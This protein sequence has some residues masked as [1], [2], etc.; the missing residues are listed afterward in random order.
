MIPSLQLAWMDEWRMAAHGCLL[1]K[2]WLMCHYCIAVKTDAAI[3]NSFK[4]EQILK[5]STALTCW[6]LNEMSTCRNKGKCRQVRSFS[7]PCSRPIFSPNDTPSLKHHWLCMSG[8]QWCSCFDKWRKCRRLY[9]NALTAWQS[10]AW[11]PPWKLGLRIGTALL[12]IN[13]KPWARKIYALYWSCF[14]AI[15]PNTPCEPP[16]SVRHFMTNKW[17]VA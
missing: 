6:G 5:K 17:A 13:C 1:C 7:H 12:L 3:I 11:S 8:H 4:C 9:A 2:S 16:L 14:Y 15:Q 10:V